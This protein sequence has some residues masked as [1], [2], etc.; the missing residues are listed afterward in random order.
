MKPYIKCKRHEIIGLPSV[1]LAERDH[2]LAKSEDLRLHVKSNID[3]E[4]RI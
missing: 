1:M 2:E 3:A 4:N